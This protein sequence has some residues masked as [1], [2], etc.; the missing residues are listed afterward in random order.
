MKCFLSFSPS[1]ATAAE[2]YMKC[3]GVCVYVFEGLFGG[4]VGKKEN[5]HKKKK[6]N[7]TRRENHLITTPKI[8]LL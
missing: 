2:N 8:S 3:V 5:T 4:Q 6:K 1:L 7:Q